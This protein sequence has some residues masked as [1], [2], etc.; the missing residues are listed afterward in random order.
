LHPNN[1]NG[2]VERLEKVK[3]EMEDKVNKELT[4]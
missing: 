3:K 1:V 4:L 2:D